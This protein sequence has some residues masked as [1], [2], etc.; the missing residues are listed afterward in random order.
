MISHIIQW[1]ISASSATRPKQMSSATNAERSCAIV[2]TR[3]SILSI[4]PGT[5]A[6]CCARNAKIPH[7]KSTVRNVE[8]TCVPNATWFFTRR[9]R[10]AN[11]TELM[12]RNKHHA[13]QPQEVLSN[14]ISH[15]LTPREKSLMKT[16]LISILLSVKNI[17]T[18]QKKRWTCPKH[19]AADDTQTAMA[20]AA[21]TRALPPTNQMVP[22]GAKVPRIIHERITTMIT[23]DS[24]TTTN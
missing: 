3:F 18:R 15:L 21:L 1:I 20:T 17:H 9:L 6:L 16:T 14:N 10:D 7:P 19:R 5:D 23:E 11:T 4:K 13:C 8:N 2:A 12:V 24:V 22:T